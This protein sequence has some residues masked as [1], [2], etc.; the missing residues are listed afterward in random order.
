MI[1]LTKKNN[2]IDKKHNTGMYFNPSLGL[3][4]EIDPRTN[5]PM[6][7]VVNKETIIKKTTN[8]G[9]IAMLDN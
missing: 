6:I 9:V 8:S 1:N 5:D 2:P 7:E 3:P 4:L